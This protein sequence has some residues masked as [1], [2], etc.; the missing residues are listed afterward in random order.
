MGSCN[1]SLSG[2]RNLSILEGLV[3]LFS[4]FLRPAVLMKYITNAVATNFTHFSRKNLHKGNTPNVIRQ[5]G[6]AAMNFLLMDKYKTAISPLLM[7]TMHLPSNRAPEKRQKRRA[8]ISSFLSGGLAGG[9]VTTA[10]YPIEFVRTRL[11]MDVGR[12]TADAP[13]LYPGGMRDVCTSI[14]RADGWRGF[15]QGYGVALAGV[16]VY[17]ALHLGG[18]DAVKTEILHSRGHRVSLGDFRIVGEKNNNVLSGSN[19]TLTMGERYLAAQIVSITAGT[20]CYPIDSI[21]RRMMMQ[22]GV[23]IEVRLY[24][25]SL[26]CFRKVLASEGIRGFFLGIGPNLVRSFGAALLLVSYDVFKFVI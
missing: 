23:P 20:A 7:W 19:N 22:A 15:Y 10:L 18:Y 13:R 5:G 16:V 14:W 2:S 21:R 24:K 11:A 4:L 1:A 9:T 6:S 12:G 26:D 17:R 25:N 3:L 8:L